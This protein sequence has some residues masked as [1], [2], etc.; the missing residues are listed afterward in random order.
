[1]LPVASRVD[2]ASKKQGFGCLYGIKM[3]IYP[4]VWEIDQCAQTYSG[5]ILLVE[6]YP[7]HTTSTQKV[8]KEGKS[9]YFREI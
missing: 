3:E 5:I 1:M 9:P 2:H 4:G 6:L 8:G 7:P